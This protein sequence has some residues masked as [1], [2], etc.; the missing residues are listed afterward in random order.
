MKSR[1][2]ENK[3]EPFVII[4]VPNYNGGI[5]LFDNKPILYN[6]LNSL[7]KLTYKNYKV[8]IGDGNSTD[9]SKEIAKKF[10]I[11][12]FR[13]KINKGPIKNNN[14][15]IKYVLKKY[16]PDYILWFNNDA[17]IT[18][19]KFLTNMINA[20]NENKKIGIE[21]VKLIYPNKKI[22][23]AGVSKKLG[24]RNRG[25]FEINRNQYNKIEE[26]DAV[27]A[28]VC[29]YN[30]NMLKKIGLF[31]E[32]YNTSCEDIDLCVRAKN[33]GYKV[34]YNGT[35]NAIHLEGFTV[36]ASNDDSI[37][38]KDFY[39]RQEDYI[40]FALKNSKS[41]LLTLKIFSIELVRS[42]FIMEDPDKSTKS[43]VIIGRKGVL[44]NIVASLKAIKGGYKKAKKSKLLNKFN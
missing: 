5:I 36:K 10:N 22:Q 19:K 25:R 27:T 12:F 23:H 1:I 30:V 37:K 21:G 24:F 2:K 9:K 7:K 4:I 38:T 31:D 14:N 18:D 13:N 44:L 16:N 43:N 6:C 29:L 34:I 41:L 33:N 35:T 32:I 26:I 17:I 20:I 40:Y 15:S 11:D 3:K 39:A 8:I 28:A 42:F